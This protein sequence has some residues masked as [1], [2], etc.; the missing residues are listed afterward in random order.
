MLRACAFFEFARNGA[1]IT[2][3]LNTRKWAKIEKSHKL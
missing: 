2:K 3:G 1:L